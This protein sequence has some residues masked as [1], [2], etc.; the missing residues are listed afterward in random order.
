MVGHMPI[1]KEERR[2]DMI[3]FDDVFSFSEEELQE[4]R[5][6]L[7]IEESSSEEDS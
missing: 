4:L 3:G 1:A 2:K 5:K 7:N 6:Q